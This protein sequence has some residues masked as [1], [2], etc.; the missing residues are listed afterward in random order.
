MINFL[1][2]LS[3]RI[4][5]TMSATPSVRWSRQYSIYEIHI[6]PYPEESYWTQWGGWYDHTVSQTIELYFDGWLQLVDTESGLLEPVEGAAGT[7]WIDKENNYAYIHLP[8]HPWLYDSNKSQMFNKV[9]Y[10]FAPKNSA[11]PADLFIEEKLAE[12]RLDK[13]SISVKLSDPISGLIKYSTFNIILDNTDGKFDGEEI[14][15]YFNTPAYIKKTGKDKAGYDD[16]IPIRA[17]MVEDI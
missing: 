11:D 4:K 15:E 1:A 13:P 2:E 16:F 7:L 10:L 17:G 3:K 6:G 9:Q 5:R 14:E 12:T 8:R